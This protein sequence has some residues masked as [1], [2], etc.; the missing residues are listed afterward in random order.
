MEANKF[1]GRPCARCK[2]TL[3]YTK[4]WQECVAC[5]KDRVLRYQ[6]SPKGKLFHERYQK[7]SERKVVQ[8]RYERLYLQTPKGQAVH[9]VNTQRQKAK[10]REAEGYYTTKDW[11]SLKES[12][13]NRCLCCGRYESELDGPLEQDHVIPLSKGGSNWITNIQP[14]CEKC[15]GMGGKGTKCTDYRVVTQ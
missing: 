14:L 12:Y 8:K 13:G 3:R 2:G 11:L 15:N 5:V 9:R 1:Q 6:Q 4:G 10:R 7:S